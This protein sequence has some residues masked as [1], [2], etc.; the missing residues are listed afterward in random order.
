MGP[1]IKTSVKHQI[2][3]FDIQALVDSQLDWENEKRIWKE[4]E[5]SPALQRRYDELVRQKKLLLQWWASEDNIKPK[6]TSL[7][8]KRE[9]LLV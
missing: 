6:T 8:D 7:K 1:Q 3:D 5:T 4:I 9:T 2:N